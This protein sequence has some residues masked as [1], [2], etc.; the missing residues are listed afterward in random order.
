MNWKHITTFVFAVLFLGV[1]VAIAQTAPA[2]AL[3]N[4]E[5]A[6]S[7][8]DTKETK[9]EEGAK[10][11]PAPKP[12]TTPEDKLGRWFELQNFTISTRYRNVTDSVDG[13]FLN[14]NQHREVIDMK[15]KFDPK[16][17]YSLN[18]HVSS[19]YYFNW[20]YADSGWGKGTAHS[21]PAL[22]HDMAPFKAKEIIPGVVNATVQ[23]ILATQYAGAPPSVI[24]QVTPILTAQVTAQVTPIVTK[25]VENAIFNQVKDLNNEGWNLYFRQFNFAAKPVQGLEVQYGGIGINRGVNTEMTSYDDDGYLVG[26]RVSVKRPKNLF[27]DEVSVTYGYLGD[28]FKPN[29]FRRMSR[30]KQGNYHQFLVRKQIGTR[31]EV[32]ADY[33]WQDKV[34]MM[35][36]AI[37][38]N[39]K[40][41]KVL[42]W[43]RFETYQ[44]IGDNAFVGQPGIF[45]AGNG[46]AVQAEKTIKRMVSVGGGYSQIDR[47][48]TALA[49]GGKPFGY[50]INGD[51]TGVGNRLFVYTKYQFIPEVSF[52]AYFSNP[53]QVNPAEFTWNK[54]YFTAGFVFDAKK[55]LQKTGLLK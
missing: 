32:S 16:G 6:D 21:F 41:I 29:F 38:V 45:K 20:A 14:Q 19:G 26:G 10:A 27:F 50:A 12:Q 52:D 17:R 30:V 44:R 49:P 47:D 25:Q 48:Y 13:P 11:A 37:K 28:L 5:A 23:Q 54:R 51:R 9:K 46:F 35:R 2:A 18:A 22:A 3:S 24:A 8:N 1:T 33:T 53:V 34:D 43:V 36:E 4:L 42:D 39:T 7:A 40:E 55:V 15:F 31:A